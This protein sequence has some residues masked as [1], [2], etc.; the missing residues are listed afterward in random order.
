MKLVV[1]YWCSWLSGV[2]EVGCLVLMLVVWYRCIWSGTD[3]VG[4]LVLMKLVV[5]YWCS[6]L[7]GSDEV[8][9]LVL[10]KLVVWY[11]C[12]WLSGSDEVDCLVLMKLVVWYWCSWLSGIDEVVCLVLMKLVVWYWWSCLSGLDELGCL[13]QVL[14]WP[15]YLI[16]SRHRDLTCAVIL[17]HAVN[18]KVRQMLT[19]L[20]T[21]EMLSWWEEL[22]LG[23]EPLHSP[24]IWDIDGG[25][26]FVL[27]CACTRL[28][29]HQQKLVSIRNLIFFTFGNLFLLGC[30]FWYWMIMISVLTC[31]VY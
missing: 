7:S 27:K 31:A 23:V 4:C 12:S 26:S 8:D 11:W 1:W 29:L 5:W 3:V 15:P 25:Q 24:T 10:M 21:L 13:Y 19:N 16:I 30:W 14:F 17:V 28:E 9:C 2:D 22:P 18:R 20:Y 6:W